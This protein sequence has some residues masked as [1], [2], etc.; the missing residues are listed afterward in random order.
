MNYIYDTS[1]TTNKIS[2]M[3][4]PYSFDHAHARRLVRVEPGPQ[5]LGVEL[6]RNFL[7]TDWDT[8]KPIVVGV[9]SEEQR[10][11]LKN[12]VSITGDYI[13]P[14]SEI[15]A[16]WAVK[17][18]LSVRGFY[19]VIVNE[20]DPAPV[21]EDT[22]SVY[23][24]VMPTPKPTQ[25]PTLTSDKLVT[26]VSLAPT[27]AQVRAEVKSMFKQMFTYYT[28]SYQGMN[29]TEDLMLL[30]TE[31]MKVEYHRLRMAAE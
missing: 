20:E 12:G 28:S 11:D 3:P 25:A 15:E 19:G 10:K 2:V 7:V 14:L 29:C 6:S 21:P 23:F 22:G 13:G 26:S 31:A 8:D 1:M 5:S 9:V 24:P 27:P 18:G 17:Y 16:I 4:I 30:V